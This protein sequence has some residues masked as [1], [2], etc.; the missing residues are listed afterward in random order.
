MFFDMD[1][2]KRRNSK[3]SNANIPQVFVTVSP[4][5]AKRTK[6][7]SRQRRIKIAIMGKA[8]VGKSGNLIQA[9]Q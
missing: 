6:S 9:L 7:S 1:T 2:L 5:L 8:G 3:S 4:E